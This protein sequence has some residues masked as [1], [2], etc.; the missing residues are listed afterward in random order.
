MLLY[1]IRSLTPCLVLVE[2]PNSSDSIIL[3]KPQDSKDFFQISAYTLGFIIFW[4]FFRWCPLKRKFYL[5]IENCVIEFSSLVSALL[6]HQRKTGSN[7]NLSLVHTDCLAAIDCRNLSRIVLIYCTAQL[8]LSMVP[9][10]D[11]IV[12]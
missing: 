4:Y 10:L 3:H 6:D 11:Y 1:I 7:Y 9:L 5:P 8:S 12:D 2:H